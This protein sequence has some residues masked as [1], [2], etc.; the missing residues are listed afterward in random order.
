MRED[1]ALY[2][3]SGVAGGT[4]GRIF[5]T[6]AEPYAVAVLRD[7]ELAVL[8]GCGYGYLDGPAQLAKFGSPAGIA[9]TNTG[10]VVVDASFNRIREIIF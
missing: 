10:L 5:V 3:F 7:G 6:G 8:T 2:Q 1:P 4:D 9:A